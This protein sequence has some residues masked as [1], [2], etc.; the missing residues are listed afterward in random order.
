MNFSEY[1]KLTILTMSDTG[2]KVT[3]SVHMVLGLN[4]EV[5]GEMP[6]AISKNDLPNFKE[7]MGDTFWYLA[8]YC[9]IHEI[10]PKLNGDLS[11]VTNTVT[12]KDAAPLLTL[13]L[14]IGIA[15]AEL[16]DLDKKNLAYGKVIPLE[17]RVNLINEVYTLLEFAAKS[18]NINTDEV[19]A[20]NI[21]KLSAR[22]PDLKFT[23]DKAINRDLVVEREILEK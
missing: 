12:L 8:N 15:I 6:A 5:I 18:L 3:D 2:S 13:V 10:E 7:E 14:S 22:Y 4:T 19:R 1:R 16:Q 17:E 21:E 20:T 11:K 9:N 23:A